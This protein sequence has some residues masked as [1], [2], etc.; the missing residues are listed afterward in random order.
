MRTWQLQGAKAHLSEVVKEAILHGPQE[1]TLRGEP[2]VVVISKK[3]YSE[4]VKPKLSF[5]EF[6]RCSPLASSGI[7]LERDASLVRD[8]DL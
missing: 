6:I 4:L 8:I 5:V 7:N 1:I 2:A 3:E